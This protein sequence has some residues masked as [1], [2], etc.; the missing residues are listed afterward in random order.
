M[1]TPAGSNIATCFALLVI[2]E[3]QVLCAWESEVVGHV[4]PSQLLMTC[5]LTML[6]LQQLRYLQ[7]VVRI[8]VIRCPASNTQI[9]TLTA[10]MYRTRWEL[11]TKR[12]LIRWARGHTA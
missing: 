7:C 2:P 1:A 6:V 3:Y 12:K 5:K 8:T 10:L 11:G 9:L 4:I